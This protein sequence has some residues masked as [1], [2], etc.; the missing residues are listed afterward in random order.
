MRMGW[1]EGKGSLGVKVRAGANA[2]HVAVVHEAEVRGLQ[3]YVE[4]RSKLWPSP[5]ASYS[6]MQSMP[7]AARSFGQPRPISRMVRDKGLIF[8]TAADVAVHA[9]VG[10]LAHRLVIVIGLGLGVGG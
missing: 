10:V 5:E 9:A 3:L 7:Q 6:T 2:D 8:D 1:G 4:Q